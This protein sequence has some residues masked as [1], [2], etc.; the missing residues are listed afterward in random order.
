MSMVLNIIRMKE[1]ENVEENEIE[2]LLS[3]MIKNFPKGL[4][5]NRVQDIFKT[6][7][8]ISPKNLRIDNYIKDKPLASFNA[9]AV[10]RNGKVYIFPRLIFDYYNYTSSIGAFSVDIEELKERR[11]KSPLRTQI[12]MWPQFLWEFLGCEDPRIYQYEDKF[13][14]LY[15]GKGYTKNEERR[16]VLAL[17]RMDSSFNIEKKDFFKIKMGNKYF[18]P[19]FMKDSAFVSRNGKE[20][21]ILVRPEINSLKACWRASADVD[22]MIL[23]FESLKPV[24]IPEPWEERIGWSTN[25]V[26]ISENRYLVG[27]HAV[28]KEDLSYRN[29]LAL[30]DN[31]GELLAISDYLLIPTGI[32]EEYGDR[33][34]VI[35][36]DGLILHN[37]LLLWI[38]GISDY[39]IGIFV[40]KIED[41][42]STLKYI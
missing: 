30:I 21:S 32:N 40:T 5:K 41:A 27:W 23:P 13:Y 2:K 38:G 15:T 26:K 31:K 34:H 12:I 42:I 19:H 17:A 11:W 25:T 20:F 6:R 22:N 10:E 39:A 37:D 14:I 1:G 24:M 7:N 18:I 9:G 36:G 29:G 3:E 33:A 28:V 8:Y 4:R 16:D 35:F